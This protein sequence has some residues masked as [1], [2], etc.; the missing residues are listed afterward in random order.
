MSQRAAV[1]TKG[2]H[3]PHANAFPSSA[4]I[5]KV[6]DF[7]YFYFVIFSSP[8]SPL[9]RLY[10]LKGACFHSFLLGTRTH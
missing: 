6:L 2:N 7:Y 9:S 1:P 4:F 8:S 3:F 5:L 10:V